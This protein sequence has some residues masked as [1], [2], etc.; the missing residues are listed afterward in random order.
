MGPIGVRVG[1]LLLAAAIVAG[2]LDLF[3]LLEHRWAT[4]GLVAAMGLVALRAAARGWRTHLSWSENLGLAWEVAGRWVWVVVAVFGL[5]WV[6][7][8]AKM[9]EVYPHDWAVPLLVGAMSGGRIGLCVSAAAWFRVAVPRRQWWAFAAM[10]GA[11]ALGV[12]DAT[13]APMAAHLR[14]VVA[15]VV[16]GLVAWAALPTLRDR[17][18]PVSSLVR[19]SQ[20]AIELELPALG[21]SLPR[22]LGA[23]I[24]VAFQAAVGVVTVWSFADVGILPGALLSTPLLAVLVVG[25]AVAIALV[26]L[27]GVVFFVSSTRVVFTPTSVLVQAR[28][29]FPLRVTRVDAKDIELRVI[30][31]LDGPMLVLAPGVAVAAD[32]PVAVLKALV[33]ELRT[34]FVVEEEGDARAARSELGSHAR[35]PVSDRGGELVRRGTALLWSLVPIPLWMVL[36][37]LEGSSLALERV[38]PD[39]M[40]PQGATPLTMTPSVVTLA[41]VL[42]AAAVWALAAWRWQSA[43]N[44][45]LA[46]L[47][48]TVPQGEDEASTAAEEP[49]SYPEHSEDRPGVRQ[50]SETTG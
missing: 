32:L 6:L 33:E 17:S 40:A 7:W 21:R 34:G 23:R 39:F 25:V 49:A 36:L 22:I 24:G 11:F 43:G 38:A 30:D 48:D 26:V 27:Q 9:S 3:G 42:G 4:L 47:E 10:A 13:A 44:T 50:P 1:I 12:R 46:T 29:L 18:A 35:R 16:A 37:K 5:R 15:A 45:V 14:P 2:R 41:S 19:R 8:V 20:E 28:L 31:D